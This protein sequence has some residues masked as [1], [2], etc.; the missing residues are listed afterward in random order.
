[1][2]PLSMKLVIFVRELLC[3]IDVAINFEPPASLVQENLIIL[4]VGHKLAPRTTPDIVPIDDFISHG[5]L[6]MRI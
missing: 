6:D 3:M 1:M 5:I 2:I 4:H